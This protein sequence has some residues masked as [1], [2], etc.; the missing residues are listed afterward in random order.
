MPLMSQPPSSPSQPRPVELG[1]WAR[2][3][4]VYAFC[5][6]RA[7]DRIIE[8]EQSHPAMETR[9]K[10]DLH[11]LETMYGKARH[12]DV[13]ASCAVTYFR[14]TAMRDARHPDFLGEW[15]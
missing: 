14:M 9:H 7:I 11:I 2:V 13:V 8:A 6:A 5:R 1:G 4:T 3:Q 12:N 15:I 10:R